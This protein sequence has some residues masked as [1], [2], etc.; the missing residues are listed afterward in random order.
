MITPPASWPLSWARM[1]VQVQLALCRALGYGIAAL[2]E[3]RHE[4]VHEVRMAAA[5]AAPLREREVLVVVGVVDAAGR[6]P[7]DRLRGAGGRKSGTGTRFGI[8][9][10]GFFA[11][12]ITVARHSQSCHSKLCFEPYTSKLSR[13]CRAV[14]NSERITRATTSLSLAEL[15]MGAFDRERRAVV[16]DEISSR[17]RARAKAAH[18]L[19]VLAARAPRHGP[20]HVRGVVHRGQ[21]GPV[22][23]PAVHVLLV[24][25]L[26]EL[27]LAEFTLLGQSA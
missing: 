12:W 24:A 6:E 4:L 25:G 8:S 27:D 23:R 19:G 26:H 13:Y 10:S 22:V 2:D 16:L 11:V 7:L 5:V 9:G 20:T 1:P 21:A 15:H 17:I 18:L 14:S 3:R